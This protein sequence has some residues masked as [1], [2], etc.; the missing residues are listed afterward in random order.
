LFFLSVGLP[1]GKA[2]L[3]RRF[4]VAFGRVAARHQD[5]AEKKETGWGAGLCLF[6]EATQEGP[7]HEGW[8]RWVAP[9]IGVARG[10]T[11]APFE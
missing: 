2:A 4:A 11:H 8:G 7:L 3:R 6:I 5:T 10:V 1:R 9:G